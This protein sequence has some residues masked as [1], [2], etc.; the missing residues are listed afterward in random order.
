LDIFP[1]GAPGLEFRKARVTTAL[2][3]A[4]GLIYLI[5]SAQ[6]FFIQTGSFWID[7]LALIPV[8]LLDYSQWYRIISSMFLHGDIF[9]ILFNMYFLYL[10]GKEVESTLGPKRYLILYFIS[11]L[12]A[13][14]FH[15]AYTAIVGVHNL[16]IPALG[17][18]GAI[19]GILGAYLLLFPHR[20]M[21]I[22]W[23]MWIFPW[24]FTTNAA[25]FLVFW[26][27]TQIIYGYA[28]IG[29]VAFFAHI[30][31][32]ICGMAL[33]GLI[34]P[35]WIREER[36]SISWDIF[37]GAYT[38]SRRRG[39][40][41]FIKLILIIAL[42]G[43][44]SSSLY[45][46]YQSKY[47]R[48][49]IYMFNIRAGYNFRYLV[50]D[51]AIYSTNQGVILSPT[52][53]LPRILINRF[54]WAGLLRGR[55]NASITP[56]NY[57]AI[58]TS[59]IRGIKVYVDMTAD[60]IYD[61]NGVLKYSKGIM[62]TDIIEIT[63]TGIFLKKNVSLVFELNSKGPIKNLGDRLIAPNAAIAALTTLYALYIVAK[64]DEDIV[65][66]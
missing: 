10:F 32:F 11:G 3:I 40:G 54:E 15:I 48:S 7:K 59:T 60:M 34:L 66:D 27:I 9:H 22:C 41:I 30:G 50:S 53:D 51:T 14:S 28:T 4:N 58:V 16:F 20:R 26:F 25:Y 52:Q 46:I 33:L 2:I 12:I 37:T 55:P 49:E 45:A 8:T 23:F 39:L 21:T 64:K 36:V 65:I 31:G 29:G 1:I 43:L 19:S 62:K 57:K 18:S 47:L 13:E 61:S 35:S 24:C 38:I 5:T 6:N 42:I 56:L 63:P 17:A 44:L